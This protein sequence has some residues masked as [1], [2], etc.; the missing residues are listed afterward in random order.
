M[1]KKTETHLRLF[2]NPS[3]EINKRMYAIFY[4]NIKKEFVQRMISKCY[5]VRYFLILILK[6]FLT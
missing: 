2:F 4:V 6:L 5:I 3:F 1:P